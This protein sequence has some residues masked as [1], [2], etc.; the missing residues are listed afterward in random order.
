MIL[1]SVGSDCS[2]LWL[3]YA[4]CIQA[5]LR[6]QRLRQQLR[7][8]PLGYHHQGRHSLELLGRPRSGTS[9]YQAMV[10]MN[11]SRLMVSRT[12]L[13]CLDEIRALAQTVN[14]C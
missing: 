1:Y 7:R 14:P 9:L 8:L 13:H 10:A 12:L 5:Q 6:L 2:G 3:G 11:S 4:Y